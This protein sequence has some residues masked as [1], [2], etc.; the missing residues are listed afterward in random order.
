MKTVGFE[1]ILEAFDVSLDVRKIAF[2]IG[3][4]FV[5]GAVAGLLLYLA[6]AVDSELL[7]VVLLVLAGLAAW[8][9]ASLV[10]GTV[11]K[12]SYDDLSRRPAQGWRSALGY[13]ARRLLT[14]LC[15]P[16]VLQIAIVLIVVVEAL[17]LL[18]A[19]IPYVGELWASLLFLP[20]VVLNLF[21]I[22]LSYLGVWL[23][24]AVVAGEGGGIIDTLR[25]IQR[26]VRRAPGRILVYLSVTVVL[27]VLAALIIIP[28]V[29]AA[30]ASTI[31]LTTGAMLGTDVADLAGDIPYLGLEDVPYVLEDLLLY[32]FGF[33]SSD[34]ITMTIAGVIF[35]VGFLL[36]PLAILSVLVIVFP[37]SCACATYLSVREE[38]PAPPVAPASW[39]E[40]APPVAPA[41]WVEPAQ[42]TC[43]NCG[44]E[45]SPQARFCLRCGYPQEPG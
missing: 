4:L 14:L 34:R 11:A 26:A 44:A 23:I 22:L 31:A 25:R 38:E 45:V 8:I 21:L 42:R 39:V 37:V 16:L 9:L 24:P 10:Y 40:P 30:T 35:A 36:I 28:L 12:M 6:L 7:A 43:P 41:S 1:L 32:R 29:Y 2:A 5:T 33:G 27:G 13:M 15:S 19:R 18:L 3:G 17:V 20:L